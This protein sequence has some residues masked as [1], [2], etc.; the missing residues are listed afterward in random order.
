MVTL[1]A[2]LL[3]IGADFMGAIGAIAFGVE[4][5]W[6]VPPLDYCTHKYVAPI[7]Q[8]KM[9]KIRSFSAVVHEAKR[10]LN[11]ARVCYN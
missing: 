4:I 10:L 1:Q 8:A 9:R 5:L 6:V 3:V 7:V 2:L 11:P